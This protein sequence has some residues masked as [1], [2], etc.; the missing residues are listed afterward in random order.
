MASVTLPP[1]SLCAERAA[2]KMEGIGDINMTALTVMTLPLVFFRVDSSP[3][4]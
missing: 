4:T 2:Q 1:K 3:T